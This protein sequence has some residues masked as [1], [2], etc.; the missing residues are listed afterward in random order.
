MNTSNVNIE[1]IMQK[2]LPLTVFRRKAGEVLKKLPQVGTFL[3]T[4]DG[5]PVA[6]LCALD[7]SE[8]YITSQQK[9]QKAK[10]LIG[11]FDLG[12][13]QSPEKLNKLIDKNYE[14]MLSGQ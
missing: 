11:G 12:I 6:K 13:R 5:K 3:I 2:I 14:K 4:K 1:D 8:S 7:T 10:S 9:V